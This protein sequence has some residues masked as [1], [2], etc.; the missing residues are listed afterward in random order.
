MASGYSDLH[1]PFLGPPPR[2]AKTS[3]YRQKSTA[4]WNMPEAYIGENEYL[5]DTMQDWMFT[6]NQTWYTERVMPWFVT[7]QIHVQWTEWENNAH[8]MGVTPHQAMSSIITQRRTIRK[9]SM[10]R[11]G[12]A[13]EFENDFVSTSMGKRSVR[14][15]H[16]RSR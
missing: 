11:R 16:F 12:I 6:A 5:R 1:T 9:A 13:A 14:V 4:K 8:F 10:L 2:P 7:E 3:P 15:P